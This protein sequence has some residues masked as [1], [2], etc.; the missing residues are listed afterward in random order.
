MIRAADLA[1]RPLLIRIGAIGLLLAIGAGPLLSALD[2]AGEIE[3]ARTRL[4]RA[5]ERA[6]RPPL[7][8][9]LAA[10]DGDALLAAFRT[11]L[12]A[13]AATGAVVIDR[14]L[15]ETDPAKPALPRLRAALRGT[16]EGL[17]GLVHALETGSPLMAVE[18]ADLDVERPAD[19]EIGRPTLM[20]LAFSVRGVVTGKPAPPGRAP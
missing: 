2:A 1:V 19:A 10:D 20:R 5:R 6:A 16:A 17:H 11:R 9:P 3:A 8:P 13:L 12:D 14:T 7:V 4:D 18:E 15:L